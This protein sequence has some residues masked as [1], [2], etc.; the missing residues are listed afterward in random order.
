MIRVLLAALIAFAF[1]AP[2]DAGRYDSKLVF[3]RAHPAFPKQHNGTI[4]LDYMPGGQVGLHMRHAKLWLDQGYNIVIRDDQ[5]SAAAMMVVAL[6]DGGAR[7]CAKRGADLY[8]HLL[9]NGEHP[10]R[11]IGNAKK[12]GKLTHRFKRISPAAF[13]IKAC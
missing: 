2:A 6:A 11:V 10:S 9:S 1:T 7:I 8:F 5:Y 13:G 4:T 3:Y 12:I